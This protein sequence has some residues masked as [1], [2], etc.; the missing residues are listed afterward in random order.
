MGRPQ[1]NYIST[2]CTG[3]INQSREKASID[4]CQDVLNM[5]APGGV[6]ERRPGYV[7][8][9]NPRTDVFLASGTA[10]RVEDV[11]G[12]TFSSVLNPIGAAY[13]DVG[14]RLYVG[15]SEQFYYINFDV[16]AAPNTNNTLFVAEYWNGSLWTPLQAIYQAVDSALTTPYSGRELSGQ[17]LLS[18]GTVDDWLVFPIPNDWALTTVDSLERYFIRFT[19]LNAGLSA[20]TASGGVDA[21]GKHTYS[22]SCVAFAISSSASGVS[23]HI[24]FQHTQTGSTSYLDI[25]HSPV[26]SFREG[27]QTQFSSYSVDSPISMVH[28]SPTNEYFIHT[29][30]S[31]V[32]VVGNTEPTEA[33]VEDRDWIV[34]PGSAIYSKNS[35]AQL[36]SWPETKFL[37]YHHGR[38]WAITD[39]VV[40]WGAGVPY[41]RVWPEITFEYLPNSDEVTGVASLGEHLYIFTINGAYRVTFSRFETSAGIDLPFYSVDRVLDGIGCVA[42]NSIQQV[43][44]NLIFLSADGLYKFDGVEAVKLTLD[45]RT[46][47]DR[48][49]DFIKTVN[50]A[51][52]K[53]AAGVNW[54]D[55]QVYLLAVATGSDI[56]NYSVVAWDYDRDTVWLWRYTNAAQ[57]FASHQSESGAQEIYFGDHQG[58]VHRLQDP[59]H[60]HGAAFEAYFE[61]EPMGLA[62]DV[63]N[64]LREVV[65]N[66]KNNTGTLT[67]QVRKQDEPTGR[68]T[69]LTFSDR[70]EAAWLAKAWGAFNW[71]VQRARKRIAGFQREGEHF[72]VKVSQTAKN[73]SFKVALMKL[74]FRAI[75]KGKR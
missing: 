48:L 74:G 34:G 25:F 38:L 45:P 40:R 55:K 58:Q 23:R 10:L 18:A 63:E 30:A 44:N 52:R 60:D 31:T 61:S 9:A 21:T 66:A 56:H 26:P 7:G 1:L 69:T 35:I 39:S 43:R 67:V 49:V 29:A 15:A 13:R 11:S 57:A 5:W 62:S 47:Y 17:A 42:Q 16:V 68:T 20:G 64:Q 50:P 37:A 33:V 28:V 14:D 71:S 75:G 73:T 27:Y 70:T 41:H 19:Y 22:P 12:G 59:P 32:L 36:G 2:S 4:Q 54:E 8:S 46:G 24:A 72:N 6:V 51:R 3:G 53:F 65:I